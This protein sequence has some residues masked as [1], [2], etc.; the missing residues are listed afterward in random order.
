ME[1]MAL[2]DECRRAVLEECPRVAIKMWV[3]DKAGV[4]DSMRHKVEAIEA[5]LGFPVSTGIYGP[6]HS[7]SVP[8]ASE[9]RPA[10]KATKA[11]AKRSQPV[12]ATKSSGGARAK[13]APP[14]KKRGM[15]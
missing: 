4:T 14:V 13:A 2:I 7:P 10:R 8:A 9:R 11:A 12:K 5:A 15:R 6:L 3:D 1:C